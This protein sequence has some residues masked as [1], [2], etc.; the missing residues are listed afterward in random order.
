MKS[1]QFSYGCLL[2][3]FLLPY[4]EEYSIRFKSTVLICKNMDKISASGRKYVMI[5]LMN[6][7]LMSDKL[8]SNLRSK[9]RKIFTYASYLRIKREKL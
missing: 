3:G 1:K 7:L 5:Q 2:L 6:F 8:L 4:S 9:R